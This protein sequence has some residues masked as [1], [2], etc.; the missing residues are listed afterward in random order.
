M[1]LVSQSRSRWAYGQTLIDSANAYKTNFTE[2][3]RKLG[4]AGIP[5]AGDAEKQGTFIDDAYQ[6]VFDR[7]SRANN[8]NVMKGMGSLF[9]GQGLNYSSAEDLKRSYNENIGSSKLSEI[10]SL[11]RE[12]KAIY[13]FSPELTTRIAETVKNADIRKDVT[14]TIGQKQKEE[15]IDNET[16]QI[17]IN[18]F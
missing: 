16:G 6:A 18:S 2:L 10:E 4:E 17:R 7:I 5:Y 9:R 12:L 1:C 3:R 13:N 8:F 14:T 11:N 15:I